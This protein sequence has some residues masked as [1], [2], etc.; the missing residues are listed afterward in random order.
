[1]RLQPGL[2]EF[3]AT[4]TSFKTTSDFS[5]KKTHTGHRLE[6]QKNMKIKKEDLGRVRA[7]KQYF[8]L[9]PIETTDTH[10]D[11]SKQQFS[12]QYFLLH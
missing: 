8:N 5:L 9:G 7:N 12:Y 6:V 2:E 11:C 10:G 1:V 3:K 4:H